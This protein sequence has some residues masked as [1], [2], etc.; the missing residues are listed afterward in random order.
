MNHNYET[1]IWQMTLAILSRW[2][3]MVIVFLLGA[4]VGGGLGFANDSKDMTVDKTKYEDYISNQQEREQLIGLYDVWINNAMDALDSSATDDNVSLQDISEALNLLQ[5]LGAIKASVRKLQ[6]GGIAENDNNRNIVRDTL[7]Q[8]IEGGIICELI[9]ILLFIS[10]VEGRE[11]IISAESVC[12]KFEVDL[13]SVISDKCS[14]FKYGQDQIYLSMTEDEQLREILEKIKV[15][16]EDITD[17]AL[18]GTVHDDELCYIN[19]LLEKNG[20]GISFSY[21]DNINESAEKHRELS[22]HSSV[23]IVEKIMKSRFGKIEREI[24]LL[25]KKKKNIIG[26]I[27]IL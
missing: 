18:V 9:W 3:E 7:I 5:N 8:I 2:R 10:F 14:F 17:I 4:L 20:E 1:D 12:D 21:I 27:G 11:Y 22:G 26:L 25:R 24:A 16:H 15:L 13:L 19:S 23:I 6:E